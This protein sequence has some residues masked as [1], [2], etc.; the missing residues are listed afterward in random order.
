VNFAHPTPNLLFA[1]DRPGRHWQ[2]GNKERIFG[3]AAP[4][5]ADQMQHHIQNLAFGPGWGACAGLDD[6]R[7]GLLRY[8]CRLYLLAEV[9]ITYHVGGYGRWVSIVPISCE[10]VI[11]NKWLD[12]HDSGTND[13]T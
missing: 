8:L 13:G 12:Q 9:G 3:S 11:E 4:S 10:I 2:R 7:I 5:T 6:G 1:T